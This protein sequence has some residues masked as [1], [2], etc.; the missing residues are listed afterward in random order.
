MYQF[1]LLPSVDVIN[2]KGIIQVCTCRTWRDSSSYCLYFLIL[3]E[4]FLET[5][6]HTVKQKQGFSYHEI[7]RFFQLLTDFCNVKLFHC[8]FRFIL[9]LFSQCLFI[10]VKKK[11]HF[12]IFIFEIIRS[13]AKITSG[14]CLSLHVHIC[15][16]SVFTC[17]FV[18][19][20]AFT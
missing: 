20:K 10:D 3:R 16:V 5:R 7:C 1:L 11:T 4:L 18:C 6:N 2:S 8:H 12:L 9:L 13:S 19:A 14:L 15:I 17:E